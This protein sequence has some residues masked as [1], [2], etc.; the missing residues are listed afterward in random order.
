MNATINCSAV[1]PLYLTNPN[2]AKG[3]APN[4]HTHDTVS[5]P[6]CGFNVKYRIT[7]TTHA[8]KSSRVENFIK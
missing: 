5:S 2:T 6:R 1:I 8:N 4:I 3:I 7:A